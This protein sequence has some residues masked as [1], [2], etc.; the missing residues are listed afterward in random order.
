MTING[1]YHSGL[2]TRKNPATLDL[3]D[4]GSYTV[5]WAGG[6]QRG[7]LSATRVS[8]R[9]ANTPR[10][11]HLEN[12]AQFTTED[13]VAVDRA[14][15]A[16]GLGRQRSLIHRLEDSPRIALVA[17][18]VIVGAVL[19]FFRYGVPALAERAVAFIPQEVEHTVAQQTLQV[20]DRVAFEPTEL[21]ERTQALIRRNFFGILRANGYEENVVLLFRKGSD[22]VGANAFA[23]PDGYIVITDQLVVLADN[24]GEIM[25]VLGHELGHVVYKHGMRRIIENSAVTLMV[26]TLTTDTNV[27][28]QAASALPALLITQKYSRDYETEADRYGLDFL[29]RAGIDTEDYAAILRKLQDASGKNGRSGFLSSHPSTAARIE[30]AEGVKSRIE[31][32]QVLD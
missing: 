10:H 13:N 23:L 21:S 20:L 17:L 19:S 4:D 18:V 12:G 7:I 3:G 9:L 27:V 28:I 25:G 26:F 22:K 1:V 15:E 31:P 14:I 29:A 30:Q 11:V 2:D 32:D 5:S 24:V 6:E 8:A 16:S